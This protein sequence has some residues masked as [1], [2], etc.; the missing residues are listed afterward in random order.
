MLNCMRFTILLIMNKIVIP[1]DEEKRGEYMNNTTFSIYGDCVSHDIAIKGGVDQAVEFTSLAAVFSDP[2][3]FS[4]KQEELQSLKGS[5]FSKRCLCL[6]VNRKTFDYLKVKRS[7]YLIVDILD[8]RMNLLK[9]ENSYITVSN[10]LLAT[11]DYLNE[12]YGLDTWEECTFDSVSLSDWEHYIVRF[13]EEIKKQYKAEQVIINRHYGVQQYIDF[14]GVVKS[15]L[16]E[17]KKRWKLINEMV[18]HLTDMMINELPG[19]HVINFPEGVLADIQNQWGLHVLHYEP[20]FYEYGANALDIIVHSYSDE[21]IR[22][23]SL[24]KEYQLK[25]QLSHQQLQIDRFERK[26]ASMMDMMRSVI[27]KSEDSYLVEKILTNEKDMEN[28]LDILY[29][30]GNRYIII[31]TVIGIL[32]KHVP[33]NIVKGIRELGFTDFNR[34]TYRMYAGVSVNGTVVCNQKSEILKESV[35]YNYN[36]NQ[37]LQISVRSAMED[38]EQ[39]GVI[40]GG[41]KCTTNESGLHF[42]VYDVNQ[43]KLVDSIKYNPNLKGHVLVHKR[44]NN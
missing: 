31:A 19:C 32:G 39:S 28:Y 34:Q 42:V 43:K 8:I 27:N 15:V 23:E 2:C 11:R 7:D 16:P 12:K 44:I 30:I 35:Q 17:T 6:D 26:I 21:E 40:I 33:G 9:K 24:R 41:K 20:L 25:M 1:K 38:N 13:V 10:E 4:I 5:N 37:D 18:K 22:L 36:V 14:D 29:Q 3:D